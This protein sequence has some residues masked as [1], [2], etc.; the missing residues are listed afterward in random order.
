MRTSKVLEYFRTLTD[1]ERTKYV[2][3]F[4]DSVYTCKNVTRFVRHITL[5]CKNS[6]IEVKR[7]L[8]KK[9]PEVFPQP[10]ASDVPMSVDSE[11]EEAF[12]EVSYH[13]YLLLN[14]T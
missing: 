6:P 7:E 2:C 3:L 4:C 13:S 5:N 10:G 1:N 9:E 12:N 11:K 14:A 8:G